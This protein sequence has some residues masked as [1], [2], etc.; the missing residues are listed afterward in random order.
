[1]AKLIS[2]WQGED[3]PEVELP[4]GA[5]TVGRD[6][7]NILVLGD[8]SVSSFHCVIDAVDKHFRLRDL[9]STNGTRVNGLRISEK[10]LYHGDVLRIG[11]FDF[12]FEAPEAL[13]PSE[14]SKA[15]QTVSIPDPHAPASAPAAPSRTTQPPTLVTSPPASIPMDRPVRI[16]I[17]AGGSGS[18]PRPVSIVNPTSL[19]PA[20]PARPTSPEKPAPSP[21][22]PDMPLPVPKPLIAPAMS[23]PP[24]PPSVPQAARIVAESEPIVEVV[25]D[26]EE[27]GLPAVP[28]GAHAAGSSA[29]SPA[30]K[31]AT[32]APVTP[33]GAAQTG[34]KK[35]V[36]RTKAPVVRRPT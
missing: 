33:E 35:I 34:K 29:P 19:P 8:A 13:L 1:M 11:N 14:P 27:A 32:P 26:E 36:L 12:R 6:E 10:K 15:N 25:D 16:P 24:A 2:L 4:D 31:P 21:V 23:R 9:L 28:T 30:A 5:T 20:T 17:A 18:G 22:A 3:G 7:L